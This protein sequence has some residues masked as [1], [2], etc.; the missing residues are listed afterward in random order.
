MGTE[1]RDATTR[2]LAALDRARSHRRARITP[3]LRDAIARELG[4]LEMDL[5][6]ARAHGEEQ[7][8][9]GKK[10]IRHQLWDDALRVLA[11][12]EML[13]PDVADVRLAL[14]EA[15]LGKKTHDDTQA[16]ITW[17]E[18]GLE[19]DPEH[20]ELKQL[21][22]R[23]RQGKPK[24]F[25]KRARIVVAIVLLVV[26]V[27]SLGYSMS[28]LPWLLAFGAE[29]LKCPDGAVSC[30]LPRLPT[31]MPSRLAEAGLEIKLDRGEF[32]LGGEQLVYEMA[33]RVH[34]MT[35]GELHRLRLTVRLLDAADKLLDER[36]WQLMPDASPPLRRGDARAIAWRE[37]VPPLTAKV[38]LAVE[39]LHTILVSGEAQRAAP[40]PLSI[41]TAKW[42]TD[43]RVSTA[44]RQHAVALIGQHTSIDGVIEIEN[45]GTKPCKSLAIEIVAVDANQ[46]PVGRAVRL[47]PVLANLPPLLPGERRAE[48]YSLYAAGN[49]VAETATVIRIE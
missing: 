26:S 18:R 6:R 30:T 37:P 9:R 24:R 32:M 5:A 2:Y 38:E 25:G 33:G 22:A 41:G 17:C 3:A 29:K 45:R 16:A 12:A 20:D 36:V 19:I 7:H 10:F 47:E 46:R 8:G 13:L 35:S 44:I 39:D 15:H 42:P 31:E 28:R 14:A 27:G 21:L 4:L 11:E 34:V 1:Q 43:V 23:L 49:A 40:L 48:R